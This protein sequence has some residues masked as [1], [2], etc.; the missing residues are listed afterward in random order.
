MLKIYIAF[1]SSSQVRVVEA[2]D[3]DVYYILF[4]NM[5]PAPKT[6]NPTLPTMQ[7]FY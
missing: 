7:L 4:P 1:S 2:A 6:L 3:P 5:D